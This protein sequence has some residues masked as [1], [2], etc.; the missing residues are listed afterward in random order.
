MLKRDVTQADQIAAAVKTAEARGMSA[1]GQYNA[2]KF[3][4]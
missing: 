2:T 1:L 4:V 3:A